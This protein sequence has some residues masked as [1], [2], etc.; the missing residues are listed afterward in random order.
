MTD[1][2][3]IQEKFRFPTSIEVNF[4]F[5]ANVNTLLA[6]STNNIIAIWAD[7]NTSKTSGNMY[8]VS[9]GAGAAF[10]ILNLE[11]HLLHDR[12]TTTLKGRANVMLNQED[13]IDVIL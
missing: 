10:S 12:Y 2:N 4:D 1:F 9:T 6:G 8:I 7:Y 11:T 5:G 13:P 3:F